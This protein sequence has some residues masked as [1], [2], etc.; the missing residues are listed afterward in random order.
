MNVN[1]IST[2]FDKI[3]KQLKYVSNNRHLINVVK[4]YTTKGNNVE[5]ENMHNLP[6]YRS[7]SNIIKKSFM[8]VPPLKEEIMLYRGVYEEEP[9]FRTV[10]STSLSIDEA[11]N[12]SSKNCCLLKIKMEQGS[13]ILP[14]FPYSMDVDEL[15]VLV[16]SSAFFYLNGINTMNY[17][18]RKMKVYDVSCKPYKKKT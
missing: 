6:K 11:L 16:D 9:L 7:F 8:D 18:G 15:E 2:Y 13:K 14:I 3:N 1:I 4:W 12:Y 17:R 10:I 5:K